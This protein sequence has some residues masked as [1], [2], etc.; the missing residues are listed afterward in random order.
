MWDE[1][2]L[3]RL[4]ESARNNPH[5]NQPAVSYK[6]L[7]QIHWKDFIVDDKTGIPTVSDLSYNKL[8]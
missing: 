8:H 3:D 5:F 7:N 4:I 1:A 6:F 2:T